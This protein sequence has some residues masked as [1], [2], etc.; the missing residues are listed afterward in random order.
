[1]YQRVNSLVSRL[2]PFF[3]VCST[4]VGGAP[5]IINP[6]SDVEGREKVERTYLSVGGSSKCAHAR[7]RAINSTCFGRR[8]AQVTVIFKFLTIA[9]RTA[10]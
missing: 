5:G 6:V 9:C 2:C 3:T 10:R 7:S 4:E 8:S 1:M